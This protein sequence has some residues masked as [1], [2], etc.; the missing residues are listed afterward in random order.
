MAFLPRCSVPFWV[1]L[2]YRGPSTGDVLPESCAKVRQGD[3]GG[4]RADGLMGLGGER[5]R[6]RGAGWRR[7][8]RFCGVAAGFG[9]AVEESEWS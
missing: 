6:L 8:G 2:A 4:L 9:L 5:R 7:T 3:D 1:G